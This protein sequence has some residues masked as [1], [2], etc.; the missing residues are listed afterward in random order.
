MQPDSVE[1]RVG[2]REDSLV[3]WEEA[4]GRIQISLLT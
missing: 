1:G 2:C 4:M 3:R